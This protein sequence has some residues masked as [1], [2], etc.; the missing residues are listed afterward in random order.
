MCPDD[1]SVCTE[2][3]PGGFTVCAKEILEA[4]ECQAGGMDECC[5][6]SECAEGACYPNPAYPMCG[7][8]Q[9]ADMNVCAQDFC[10]DDSD[11]QG[12]GEQFC[13]PRGVNRNAVRYCM[14]KT[15]TTD[16]DCAAEPGG[17][18]APVRNPC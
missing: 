7:G 16:L 1:G 18:C 6:S 17:I 10:Q 3:V 14:P 12:A 11:C 2:M 4:T 5:D 9:P 15:C 13:A 8:A